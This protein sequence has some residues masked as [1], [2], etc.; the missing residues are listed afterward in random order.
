MKTCI[1]E[2]NKDRKDDSDNILAA[3]KECQKDSII[4][5]QEVEYNAFTPITL[6][7]LDNVLVHLNGNFNLPQNMTA[8]QQAINVMKN[9]FTRKQSFGRSWQ[10]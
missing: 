6:S 7:G 5:F 2:H 4:E 3:F 10:R 1:V 8:V 9:H